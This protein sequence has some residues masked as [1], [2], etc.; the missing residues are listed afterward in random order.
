MTRLLV[1]DNVYSDLFGR[2]HIVETNYKDYI[3][4]HFNVY[5]CCLLWD[6]YDEYR[7]RIAEYTDEVEYEQEEFERTKELYK[8]Y[9]DEPD[10]LYIHNTISRNEVVDKFNNWI[11][12]KG[13]SSKI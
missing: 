3:Q 10:I 9:V 8:K 5:T 4:E 7:K 6:S 1:T 13:I 2:H 12:D 11:N